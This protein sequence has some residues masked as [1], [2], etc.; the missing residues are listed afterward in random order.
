MLEQS[1]NSLPTVLEPW[2]TESNAALAPEKASVSLDFRVIYERW[3]H[4]VER[5]IRAMGGPAAERADLAQDVFIVVHRRLPYFVGDN[6]AGW[7]YQI[8]RHRVRDFR[9]LTWV[10]HMLFRSVPLEGHVARDRRA[11]PADVLETHEK[12]AV[13]QH[14]LTRLNAPERAA[15]VLFE[16]EGYSG[17]EIATIQGVSVNTVWARIYKARTKLRTWL[18]S[19]EK[20]L[21][22]SA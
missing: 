12:K 11:S 7:L 20:Q 19:A 4:Q 22:Q 8:A 14:L 6:I 1:V 21:R 16:I 18:A 10:R 17:E 13:L 3:F 5:W 9:R 2:A 15:L